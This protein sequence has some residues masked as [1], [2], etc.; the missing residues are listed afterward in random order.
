MPSFWSF[1]TGR[2]PS[3]GKF[4][5]SLFMLRPVMQNGRIK[6]RTIGPDQHSDLGIDPNLVKQ[7]QVTQWAVQ[8]ATQD[9]LKVDGPLGA[10]VKAN[11]KRVSRGDFE[12][13]DS[14]N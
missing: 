11:A 7:L 2:L 14:I 3:S 12:G 8:L 6:V 13:A 10:V 9:R 1:S 4:S 5:K